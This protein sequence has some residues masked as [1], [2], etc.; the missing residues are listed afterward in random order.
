V[1]F[2][3]WNLNKKGLIHYYVY[4]NVANRIV[5][6]FV[7][8]K[9]SSVGIGESW[10]EMKNGKKLKLGDAHVTPRNIQ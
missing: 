7:W 2:L 6:N 8:R 3:S 10:Y 5:W 4:A 1:V 9:F